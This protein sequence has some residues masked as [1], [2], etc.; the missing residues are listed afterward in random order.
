MRR[1]RRTKYQWL[2]N[3]GQAGVNNQT[4]EDSAFISAVFNGAISDGGQTNLL[5]A[6]L[7]HDTPKEGAT[8][9][10]VIGTPLAYLIGNDYIL[11]RIVGKCFISQGQRST[12]A[13]NTSVIHT[14]GIFIARADDENVGTGTNGPVGSSALVTALQDYGP[15]HL[16]VIREP[17][18]WR[19]SW[20][21]SVTSANP[22]VTIPPQPLGDERYPGT[23]AG[24]GSVLDG[25]H[26]DA[27]TVRRVG[28]D[29]RL[30]VAWQA[31]TFP[32]NIG[33]DVNEN[34]SALMTLDLRLL[35]RLTKARQK[36]S[37]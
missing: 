5:I 16:D 31:R 35:G 34:H 1:R 27:K 3:I 32:I 25:P 8:D 24:Y 20:I 33:G 30:F 21:L 14:V 29:N 10:G 22:A 13:V 15:Q 11:R 12:E 9:S 26:I 28:Q 2:P 6:P 36:G 23:T 7:I 37:F 17:W 4:E 19:R 18:I